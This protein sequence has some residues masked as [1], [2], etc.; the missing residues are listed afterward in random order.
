MYLIKMDMIGKDDKTVN[1]NIF[2]DGDK[3]ESYDQVKNI[4]DEVAN[5]LD[6]LREDTLAGYRIVAQ[7]FEG[8]EI[9]LHGVSRLKYKKQ[10]GKKIT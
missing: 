2:I 5:G 1:M 10:K 9:D 8:A 4:V 3:L 6:I 7:M